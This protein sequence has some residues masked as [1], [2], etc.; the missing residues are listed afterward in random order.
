MDEGGFLDGP[1]EQ[2]QC[3]EIGHFLHGEWATTTLALSMVEG[4]GG[5][6]QPPKTP[7]APQ[8]SESKYGFGAK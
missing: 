1:L 6:I 3:F 5:E 8:S 4:Q 7:R 2:R